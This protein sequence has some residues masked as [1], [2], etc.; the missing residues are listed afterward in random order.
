[1]A[2]QP[3]APFRLRLRLAMAPNLHIDSGRKSPGIQASAAALCPLARQ[4]PGERMF[5]SAGFLSVPSLWHPWRPGVAASAVRRC[6]RSCFQSAPA[7]IAPAGYGE[8]I[9]CCPRPGRVANACP[10]P[11]V[12]EG[13]SVRTARCAKGWHTQ[14]PRLSAATCVRESRPTRRRAARGSVT[15]NEK[16]GAWDKLGG[17]LA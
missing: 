2:R 11:Q 6:S 13:H 3:P 4:E 15:P 1:M 9:E 10:E 14:V 5:A 17:I 8:R 7:G 16:A 12:G